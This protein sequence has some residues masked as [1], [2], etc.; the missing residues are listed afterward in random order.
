MKI[1][2]IFAVYSA[3]FLIIAMLLISPAGNA[4]NILTLES[5]ILKSTA[6]VS[7]PDKIVIGDVAKG[8]SVRSDKVYI[9]NTG[10]IDISVT[11]QLVNT[12][13]IFYNYLYFS[14]TATSGFKSFGNFSFNIT[15]PDDLGNSSTD[16]IYIKLD[17]TNYA[18][19]ITQDYISYQKSIRF[20]A[21]AR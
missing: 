8:Y 16:Y 13:E 21:M 19:N 10:N 17:L 18:G 15:K 6:S 14:T 20:V 11:P 1:R 7:V 4:G 9:N 2:G 12:T 3:I 5:N